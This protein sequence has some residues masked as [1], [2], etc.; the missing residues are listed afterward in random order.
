MKSMLV[1]II[2]LISCPDQQYSLCM[3]HIVGKIA[4]SLLN[5]HFA[6]SN[7]VICVLIISFVMM[8]RTKLSRM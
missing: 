5:K 1:F 7:F 2:S 6:V 4:I 3:Y 8:S